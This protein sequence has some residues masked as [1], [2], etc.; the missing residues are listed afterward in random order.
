MTTERDKEIITGCM[1]LLGLPVFIGLILALSSLANAYVLVKLWAWFV[2]P[3]FAAP[4]LSLPVA[5]GVGSII[6]LLQPV[7]KDDEKKDE[8]VL[9]KWGR[10]FG[11]ITLKPALY[12]LVGYIASRFV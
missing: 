10:L 4:A 8:S 6:G 5:V 1:G 12:L 2:V 3:T 9:S 7:P 11:Q